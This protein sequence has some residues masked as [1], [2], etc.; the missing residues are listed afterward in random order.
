M[1]WNGLQESADSFTYETRDTRRV[2][3]IGCDMA[4]NNLAYRDL[5]AYGPDSP[6][7]RNQW[8]YGWQFKAWSYVDLANAG[9]LCVSG[10]QWDYVEARIECE[11]GTAVPV[12]SG[13]V[14]QETDS[15]AVPDNTGWPAAGWYVIGVRITAAGVIEATIHPEANDD[16][17]TALMDLGVIWNPTVPYCS[18]VEGIEVDPE[19]AAAVVDLWKY[20]WRKLI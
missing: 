14:G 15:A 19:N 13:R 12:W 9:V 20:E 8:Q 16:A 7:P 10:G 17:W 18:A 1:W 11:T 5:W 3:R 6:R 2:I 4:A